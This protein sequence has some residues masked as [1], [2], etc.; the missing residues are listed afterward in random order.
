MQKILIV[1]LGN[2][3]RSPIAEGVLKSIAPKNK[4]FIESAAIINHHQGS[5]PDSRA[6]Q[7]AKEKGI[8]ISLQKS[9]PI[10]DSDFK[11]YDYIFAMDTDVLNSLIE[12]SPKKFHSKIKLYSHFQFPDMSIEVPDPYYGE[13][14]DFESVY[15]MVYEMSESI[16]NH[17][18]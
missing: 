7:V 1:C 11:Y 2:I 9:A 12:K 13:K 18:K 14:K 6:I 8:D 5:A 3:C 10:K 15:D 4:Y 17:I 16:V